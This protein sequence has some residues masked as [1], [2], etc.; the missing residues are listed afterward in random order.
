MKLYIPDLQK[1]E[2]KFFPY[3]G[4]VSLETDAGVKPLLR[5]DLQAASI[6]TRVVIKGQWEADL[7]GECS[8]CLQKFDYSLKE[9]FYEEFDHLHNQVA[10]T[11]GA[12]GRLDLEAGERF[13]FQGDFLNLKE[14]FRQSFLMSQ[15]LK[16][17]CREDC[18]GLCPVCGVDR[19]K[20]QCSCQ[21]DRVDPRWAA[22]QK[23]KDKL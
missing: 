6:H 5:I 16:I 20:E 8:R 13:V 4:S 19:N 7:Q 2:G 18:Q 10:E 23:I 12:A 9:D 14:Y 22:L 17:L 21:Q 1:N 15:P 3:K 11:K